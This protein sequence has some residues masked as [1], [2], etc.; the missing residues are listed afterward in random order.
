MEKI[1]I[2]FTVAKKNKELLLKE[3]KSMKEEM[4]KKSQIMYIGLKMAIE[5]IEKL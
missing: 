4:L 5:T 1:K 3:L 2:R